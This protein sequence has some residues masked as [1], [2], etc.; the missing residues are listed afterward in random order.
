MKQMIYGIAGVLALTTAIPAQAQM[1]AGDAMAAQAQPATPYDRSATRTTTRTV[2]VGETQL[3]GQQIAS[4]LA[5]RKDATRFHNAV[6]STGLSASLR[7]DEDGY[8]AFVPL[9][10]A[11]D[12][13][14][15]T[16]PAAPAANGEVNAGLRGVL[17]QHVVDS[18]YDLKLMHG[19][20]DRITALGGNTITVTKVGN[21]YYANGKL[22]LDRHRDP[23]GIIYFIDDF[24]TE[25]GFT[26][27]A[28]YNPADATK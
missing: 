3:Y 26:T 24:V 28:I 23:E 13:A 27:T 22:I 17:E 9:D 11:F 8:T 10:R 6:V 4:A 2:V 5:E 25:P 20:R 16:P 19:N 1:R 15:I 21:R 14:A 7:D 12:K 18:K